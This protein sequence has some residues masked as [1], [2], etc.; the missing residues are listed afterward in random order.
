M[1]AWWNPA[2]DSVD[3]PAVLAVLFLA[4]L[5][6]ASL[7]L[8][9][10]FLYRVHEG[11]PPLAYEPRRPVPWT[12]L[13]LFILF[14]LFFVALIA[15]HTLYLGARPISPRGNAIPPTVL[16]VDFASKMT[17]LLAALVG[18]R[19]LRG[20]TPSDLGLE[21]PRPG[22]DLLIGLVA[23]IAFLPPV[24]ALQFLVHRFNSTNHP[25]ID[26]LAAWDEP[27]VRMIAFLSAGLFAPVW[28]EL[29]FR[30]LLQ[31]WLERV[32][33]HR[34]EPPLEANEIHELATEDESTGVYTV[35]PA[36]PRG[37]WLP[38]AI[39][40]AV[41][42]LMHVDLEQP[43]LDFIPL[44]FFACGLGYLYGRTHR[45]LPSIVLHM[46]LNTCSLALFA[47]GGAT[48]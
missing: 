28:E 18:L 32:L 44:F 6:S 36:A 35:A 43:R 46:A 1:I 31:G 13:D 21:S 10:H 47:L 45:A 40:S 15:F 26:A 22:H 37:G 3:A 19:S 4:L 34:H 20:A 29:F 41:F 25:L 23:A 8:W 16:L 17:V 42:A 33:I 5:V 11:Q 24:Y 14:A 27:W 38:I 30:V 48:K 39:S 12:F 2:V 9:I 7:T